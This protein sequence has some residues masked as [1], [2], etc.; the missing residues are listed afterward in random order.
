MQRPLQVAIHLNLASCPLQHLKSVAERNMEEIQPAGSEA[1]DEA[2]EAALQKFRQ[3]GG[4]LKILCSHCLFCSL[5]I[6]YNAKCPLPF[7]T[8][9]ACMVGGGQDA[10]DFLAALAENVE[11][12]AVQNALAAFK[13]QMDL[14]DED[15]YKISNDFLRRRLNAEKLRKAAMQ[16]NRGKKAKVLTTAEAAVREA[17]EALNAHRARLTSQHAPAS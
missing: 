12:P 8:A 5:L 10:R 7:P 17:E 1:E 6:G 11:A 15:A 2:W 3:A 13:A 16:T 14:P 4:M 9:L